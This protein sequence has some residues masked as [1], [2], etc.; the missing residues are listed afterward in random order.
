M[1]KKTLI[2]TIVNFTCRRTWLTISCQ[3]L[4]I[5]ILGF[6]AYA[7][8]FNASFNF[9]DILIILGNPTVRN[10][11]PLSDPMLFKGL[12]A[13]GDMTFA[14]NY[15]IGA[16][17]HG[18]GFWVRGYHYVNLAIHLLNALALYFFVQLTLDVAAGPSRKDAVLAGAIPFITSLFFV[19]HPLQTQAVTYIVQRYTSLAT[20]FYLIS[21]VCY[22]VAR[23]H[24][25]AGKVRS[26]LFGLL[27]FVAAL[28]AMRTKEISFT[29]P[30]MI[31]VYEFIFFQGNLRKRL[32]LVAGCFLIA[33]VIPLTMLISAGGQVWSRLE[34]LTKVQTSMSR[35][36]YLFTQFRVIVAYLRL[37]FFPVGQN[38]DHDID[39]STSFFRL[40]VMGS[41]GLLLVIFL[42]GV[43][44]LYRSRPGRS[45]CAEIVK[46]PVPDF[47]YR[48][49][50]FGIFW[51]FIA[52]SVE[53][54][55]IPI[56]DVM[57]EH[58]VYLPSVGFF[59]AIATLLV[60]VAER[61]AA[62]KKELAGIVMVAALSVPVLLGVLTYNRNTVWADDLTLW[63]D[64]TAKSPNKTRP[65]NNL[66]GAY[67]KL[68]EPNKA[69]P[70]LIKSITISPYHPD[71]Y[72]N[73][74]KALMQLGIYDG[75]F[76]PT[77]EMFDMTSGITSIYQAEWFALAYNNLGLAYDSLGDRASAMEYFRK[78]LDM[79]P[80]LGEARLNLALSFAATGDQAGVKEQYQTLKA[81]RPELAEKLRSLTNGAL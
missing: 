56:V 2:D 50:A 42:C 81:I 15:R 70:A 12:R 24:W 52:L 44:L 76:S 41:F 36:D 30:F 49:I 57:F 27:S 55:F 45:R 74:G 80:R 11:D 13:V 8:T 17:F 53:S 32:A 25:R 31:I 14:L 77:Y 26:C 37:L 75:R 62:P 40:P 46:G 43:Y 23:R 79:N 71:A 48:L 66:A 4:I 72:N 34:N 10:A 28:L 39:V 51:F 33:A 59:L 20:L 1:S 29:L 22:V 21:V 60:L 5:F 3:L 38:L 19:S 16:A 35:L 54:S 47:R 73:I 58:R 18:N 63:L 68:G 65:W 64:T 69:I 7:N 61:I 78:S 67:L 6:L 9:D